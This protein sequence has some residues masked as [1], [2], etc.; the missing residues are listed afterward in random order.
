MPNDAFSS[1]SG[2]Q[3][4]NLWPCF[5]ALY[6]VKN[7]SDASNNENSSNL[8]D[9]TGNASEMAWAFVEDCKSK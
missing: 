7:S 2:L 5:P 3:S 1:K 8:S 9:G 6:L 4:D